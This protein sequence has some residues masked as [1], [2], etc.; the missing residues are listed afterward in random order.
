MV[1]AARPRIAVAGIH[2]ES[3]PNTPIPMTRADFRHLSARALLHDVGLVGHASE[4][5][6]LVGAGHLRAPSGGRLTSGTLATVIDE[7]LDALARQGSLDGLLLTSHGALLA[8]DDDDADA[9]WIEAVRR[10]VGDERLIVAAFDP[11]GT[12]SSRTLACLDGVVTF[13][14]TPHVDQA[15]TMGRGLALL[16]RTL[17]APSE[18]ALTWSGLPL[19]VPSERAASTVAPLRSAYRA[20][21]RHTDTVW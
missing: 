20:L 1:A 9:T 10:H 12:P 19:R 18:R 13:R 14:T 5:F 21:D 7:L 2:G 16:H 8:E 15:Q 4:Q 3:N 11:H 6:E 17:R